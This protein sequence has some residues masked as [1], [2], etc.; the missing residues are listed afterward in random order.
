MQSPPGHTS[1]SLSDPTLRLP[2][3]FDEVVPVL[4]SAWDLE[5]S[6]PSRV[7]LHPATAQAL[8]GHIVPGTHL[9][10]PASTAIYT[11]GSFNGHT[12]AWAFCVID[13]WPEGRRLRGWSRGQ[14]KLRGEALHIGA[15]S[16]SA[17]DAERSAL[18]WAVSWAL[19]AEAGPLTIWTD[20]QVASSQTSGKWGSSEPSILVRACRAIAQAAEF[21]RYVCY[22]AYEHIRAHAGDPYNELVDVLAKGHF[23]WDSVIPPPKRLLA[24]WV[25]N[26]NIDWLW[27]VCGAVRN[28][29]AWPTLQGNCLVD[30]QSRRHDMPEPDPAFLGITS[31]AAS[32]RSGNSRPG[33]FQMTLVAATI[34]VQTLGEDANKGVVGRVPYIRAQLEA[35]NICLAGLQ[36]TRAKLTESLVSATHYRFTSAADSKGCL[37]VELW[38]SKNLPFG[39]QADKPLF[40]SAEDFRVLSWS[41]R[42]LFAKC[43]RGDFAFLIAVCHA[44]PAADVGREAWWRLFAA[45]LHKCAGTLPVLILGDLNTRLIHPWQNR[46]G[47]LCWETGPDPPPAFFDILNNHRLWVPATF[48]A[49]HVGLSHTW[50]SPGHGSLSRIDF[51]II[52][53][54]WQVGEAGSRILHEVDF[55]QTGVDH[56]AAS[57]AIYATVQADASRPAR[58]S[59]V[60]VSQLGKPE[61]RE[62]VQAIC[63]TIP[64]IEWGVDAH[65]HYQAFA[66]HLASNLAIAFPAQKQSRKRPYISDATWSLRQRRVNLRRDIHRRSFWIASVDLVVTLRAWRGEKTIGQALLW[67]FAEILSTVRHLIAK[68]HELRVLKADLR[69]SLLSDRQAYLRDVAHSAAVSTVKSTVDRLRPI[70]GPP[71]RKQR[72]TQAIPAIRLENGEIAQSIEQTEA[73]WI[74]HFSEVEAGGP[75]AAEQIIDGCFKRQWAALENDIDINGEDLIT[76]TQLEAGLRASP[77]GRAAGKDNVPADLLHHYP[78]G[79]AR[80][81]YPIFLKSALRSQEPIQW[82]GGEL[83]SIWKR[84]GSML[85]CTS[86]R[87]ILVSSATGKAIHG[88]LRQQLGPYF[89]VAAT[90]LQIGGRKGYPVQLALQAARAW[91]QLCISSRTSCAL[92]FVDLRDAFHRV[93]RALVHGGCPD[94]QSIDNTISVLGLSPEVAPRLQAYVTQHSLISKAGAP[95]SLTGLVA[96]TGQD[97]WFTYGTLQGAALVHAGTRPG[98]NLADIVF[99]FLFSEL[100]HKLRQRFRDEGLTVAL[101]WDPRWLAASPDFVADS[102]SSGVERPI[103]ITWMD[104]LALLVQGDEPHQLIDRVRRIATATVDECISATLVP[105][106]AAGKTECVVALVGKG[107]KNVGSKIFRGAEPT[108]P[109]SSEIWPSARLRLVPT[110]K[111]VG[112]IIQAGGGVDRET[113]SRIGA[114]WQAFRKHKRQVFSSPLVSFRDKVVL[115]D[116]LVIS[117]MFYGTGAWPSC[118]TATIAKFHTALCAMSR[119]MLRPIFSFEAAR[120]VSACY[121]LAV[122]GILP[123]DDQFDL[124]RLRHFKTVVLKA[125]P[126]LWA[127]LHAEI[128]WLRHVQE[129]LA[130]AKGLLGH[131]SGAPADLSDWDGVVSFI[132][133]SPGRWKNLVKKLKQVASLVRRWGAEIQQYHGLLFRQLRQLGASLTIELD[134]DARPQE[135]CACCQQCFADTRAWSHHAFKVHGRTREERRLVAGQQCPACLKHFQT[136]E[137]LCNHVRHSKRCKTMLIQ[138]GASATPAPGIGSRAYQNAKPSQLPSVQ[139]AGPL[140]PGAEGQALFEAQT[141]SQEVLAALED[142]F[143]HGTTT[144]NSYEA[145]VEA[146]R[147]CFLPHCLQVSRLKATAVA[148]HSLLS[149]A[150]IDDEHWP[151]AWIAWHN[152][153]ANMLLHV[154]WADWLVPDPK[155]PRQDVSTFRDASTLLPW[156]HFADVFL[157]EPAHEDTIGKVVAQRDP[158][159]GRFVSHDFASQH[160][161]RLDFTVLT[162]ENCGGTVVLSCVGLLGSLDLPC[163]L[164]SFKNLEPH[165]VRLRLFSDLARAALLLWRR[166]VPCFL[167]VPEIQCPGIQALRTVAPHAVVGNGLTAIG[168]VDCRAFRLLSLF[169]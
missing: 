65:T 57:L 67:S 125:C 104:D 161:E 66:N 113:R 114:A 70:I 12:S 42:H 99:G 32:C 147:A 156:M 16:H 133:S 89:D 43:A 61:A 145:V 53:D 85:D 18:F 60:D 35:A 107:A 134:G 55:A 124:E 118:S 136:N 123:A 155:T 9:G 146:Y 131:T 64:S 163:P 38:V 148:W 166:G 127:L 58:R 140:F 2:L 45:D 142:F 112:G 152:R 10:C 97:T 86:H 96:E 77:C 87:A 92:L 159:T 52:P 160:P 83:H 14:V 36:E 158:G 54:L 56:F 126:E 102:T 41:P 75:C 76:L 106:L 168:N 50:A 164:S 141:P 28:P 63:A 26:S 3:T 73:R 4:Q 74:R 122:V 117:T 121:A 153:V 20:S 22:H 90:P 47:E 48:T 44:P 59:R 94:N 25:A 17:I 72:G 68:V 128:S 162:A 138:Q 62:V 151:L 19:S 79:I 31:A 120:H 91:Q 135:V 84:K 132:R 129:S 143:C 95:E 144:V 51:V 78:A 101:P 40:F 93:A 37:G 103:D 39:Y 137:K 109:L 80:H 149:E 23:L 108:I 119:M 139:A 157:P 71:K 169:N 49:C 81:L 11:D 21:A 24:D 8:K 29:S 7:R 100:L 46:I 110:Y 27:L 167:I 150:Q 30:T 115:H 98:D 5:D 6:I 105:N 111:H 33:S 34:N 130:W 88:A 154:S 82:K 13:H 1:Y 69:R 15:T 165:L 116:S